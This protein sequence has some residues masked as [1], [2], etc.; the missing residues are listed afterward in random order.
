MRSL[1]DV[2]GMSKIS[3][4]LQAALVLPF[5]WQ[6]FQERSIP[7][8]FGRKQ[9]PLTKP[10]HLPVLRPHQSEV[11]ILVCVYH[12]IHHF[13]SGFKG[14]EQ[15]SWLIKIFLASYLFIAP[16]SYLA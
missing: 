2:K 16:Q 11:S 12:R 8:R 3:S 7:V 1:L 6:A 14:V 5:E 15:K 10:Q 9:E 4:L 13:I